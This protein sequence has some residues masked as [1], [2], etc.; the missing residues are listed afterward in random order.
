[1]VPVE[2][3]EDKVDPNAALPQN[4]TN[5]AEL[6]KRAQQAQAEINDL[7]QE[8]V[9][10]SGT[11]LNDKL[12]NA[13]N[14][15]DLTSL[16][17]LASAAE[18]AAAADVVEEVEENA[19]SHTISGEQNNTNDFT[20]TMDGQNYQ[21]AR[22]GVNQV[23][24]DGQTLY[25]PTVV[26]K[27][28]NGNIM[29]D[30]K[31]NAIEYEVDPRAGNMKFASSG[32]Y[33]IVAAGGVSGIR[34][35]AT[36]VNTMLQAYQGGN[37]AGYVADFRRAYMAGFMN[38]AMPTDLKNLTREQAELARNVAKEDAKTQEET[39]RKKAQRGHRKGGKLNTEAIKDLHL[40]QSMR[41]AIDVL[42]DVA[43]TLGVDID[44]IAE[45]TQGDQGSYDYTNNKITLNL[46]ANNTEKMLGIKDGVL[47]NRNADGTYTPVE[48]SML[49]DIAGHELT[50]YIRANSVDEYS[51]L[52]KLVTERMGTDAFNA[53]VRAQMLSNE[54]AGYLLT[55]SEAVEEVVCDACSKMLVDTKAIQELKQKD[56]GLFE[57]FKEWVKS[58]I[59]KLLNADSNIMMRGVAQMYDENSGLRY[60]AQEIAEAWDIAIKAAAANV[61][62]E[63]QTDVPA[64]EMAAQPAFMQGENTMPQNSRAT[65]Y[66]KG[67]TKDKMTGRELL[68][69][70]ET[71]HFKRL[72][73]TGTELQK[74]VEQRMRF[75]DAVADKMEEWGV[76]YKALNLEKVNSAVLHRGRDGK[77]TMTCVVPNAE[78]PINID[79]STICD[80][81]SDVTRLFNELANMAPTDEKNG[82]LLNELNLTEDN[83][84][85]INDVLKR[86][87]YE[88]ACFGCFV[89]SKRF[90]MQ[91]FAQSFCDIYN[92]IVDT[93]R[94]EKG[95]GAASL[96]N[97]A[98]GKAI[99]DVDVRELDSNLARYND[100]KGGVA[101]GGNISQKL[102]T[103]IRQSTSK[104]GQTLLRHLTVSDLITSN[105]LESL[106]DTV[107]ELMK[108]FNAHYGQGRPKN[109][110]SYVPYHSEVA[111]FQKNASVTWVA[112]K[113]VPK[114]ILAKYGEEVAD[115]DSKTKQ[116]KVDE[117]GNPLTKV[118]LTTA[119]AYKA[120]SEYTGL[121]EADC[122]MMSG[123]EWLQKY[124][125]S[126]GGVRNQSFSD[127]IPA[128]LFDALQM[129][130]DCESRGF[131][132]QAYTKNRYRAWL[133][134][135]VNY[136][137]NMS[138]MFLIDQNVD[139]AHAGLDANGNYLIADYGHVSQDPNWMNDPA[140]QLQSISW[141]DAV[142]IQKHKLYGKTAGIIG[143]GHSYH[144]MVKMMN[145]FNVPYIIGYHRSGLPVQVANSVGLFLSADYTDVQNMLQMP[146]RFVRIANSEAFDAPTYATWSM[147]PSMKGA[148]KKQIVRG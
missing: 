116:Q 123:Q 130:A 69:Q 128:Q 50:H 14:D 41:D 66:Y 56:M 100:S 137:T 68:R 102:E 58:F 78:Y 15:I 26:L 84:R 107:P 118:K 72:G 146:D 55:Y 64:Q 16:V 71:A 21:I 89:E 82:N 136:K 115:I 19:P 62:Q 23:T 124:I 114:S 133:L 51:R 147:D 33:T 38:Q 59:D 67:D 132:G 2:E 46:L 37:A 142:Q 9:D 54:N 91:E 40:T 60:Y 117:E 126:I 43:E 61:R 90:I 32:V 109:I 80:K 131:A 98:R 34:M 105:G 20:V 42:Q 83:L 140:K 65:Y 106:A 11:V 139:G 70:N 12:E 77:Y 6:F 10:M 88:T 121:N 87:G 29:V 17:N 79:F 47:V 125:L 119:G 111:N 44:V 36:A 99:T 74:K 5:A 134:G 113:M 93:V 110:R 8:V 81:R 75:M 1:M 48:K 129:V 63:V 135:M 24:Q 86:N 101:K 22:Y 76:K 96:F 95:L 144:H 73:F 35:G 145:D 30:E 138:V 31:G 3:P 85:R 39:R 27:D 7:I 49:L 57:R 45:D 127:F 148:A 112:N 94:T 120:L 108:I 53:A 13:I 103:L 18:Q 104:G 122:K 141:N 92:Q 52:V 97:F 28:A 4:L 143:V 25:I